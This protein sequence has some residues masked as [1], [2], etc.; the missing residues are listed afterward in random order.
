MVPVDPWDAVNKK[1]VQLLMGANYK[2]FLSLSITMRVP[3]LVLAVLLCLGCVMEG[4]PGRD[5]Y[6][7]Y[8]IEELLLDPGSHRAEWVEVAGT[9]IEDVECGG[10]VLEGSRIELFGDLAEHVGVGGILSGAFYT[11][12][13]DIECGALRIDVHDFKPQAIGTIVTS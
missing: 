2:R 10:Y 3:V 11:S 7:P 1:A 4:G 12:V 9:I 6:V 5:E 13:A 8:E